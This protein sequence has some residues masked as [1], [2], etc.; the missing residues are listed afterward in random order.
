[1]RCGLHEARPSGGIAARDARRSQGVGPLRLL[2]ASALPYG[3][4]M[5]VPADMID[6]PVPDLELPSS[7]GGRFPLRGRVG[8]G[9]LVLFFYIRNA[10]P[11]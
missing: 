4:E 8:I 2:R 5:S 1:V 7:Q 9:P 10:T 6:R 11:G 3:A